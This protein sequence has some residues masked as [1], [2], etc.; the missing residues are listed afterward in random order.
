MRNIINDNKILN[1]LKLA[2]V[3]RFMVLTQEIKRNVR[4]RCSLT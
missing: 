2:I 1:P 3:L 4:F